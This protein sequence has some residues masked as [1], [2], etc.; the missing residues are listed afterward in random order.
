MVDLAEA[1]CAWAISTEHAW[2]SSRSASTS[3]STRTVAASVTRTMSF[4]STSTL[5]TVRELPDRSL[6]VNR[7]WRT[8]S[9]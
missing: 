1:A 4:R 2:P 7:F 6:T 8:C 5:G 3:S 9:R